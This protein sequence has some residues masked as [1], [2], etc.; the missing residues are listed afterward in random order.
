MLETSDRGQ[1]WGA[2]PYEALLK[3][4]EA[5]G[6]DVLGS[7][8]WLEG[9]KLYRLGFQYAAVEMLI[10]EYFLGEEEYQGKK[11]YETEWK[12][13]SKS[14]VY[15]KGD[16]KAD[17]VIVR[18][19]SP[20]ER[21]VPWRSLLDYLPQ[22]P[23]PLFVIDLSMKFLHTPEELS[24]L[25]LQLG[26][27]LSTIRE[28]LWDAH[29]SITGADEE[30]AKWINEVMGVNK[31]A[32]VN[33]RP[34]EV[35]WGYDA[36]KVIILRPD[37][38]TPL[39]PDDVMTADAFLIGGIVDKIPR[40]GLSRMLDSLV[41]WGVPRRIELRGSV[42]GVPE[43][44]NRIVEVLLKSRYVYNGDIE[45]AVITTMSKKDRVARAYRELVKYAS[46]KGGVT[47]VGKD[48]YD[49][50]RQWLPLSYDEFLEAAR[51]AHVSVEGQT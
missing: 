32:I 46:E 2:R 37:A 11:V 6:Y 1:G 18:K 30:T 4:M 17:A 22:P 7:R 15:G 39:K 40:P 35:L 33:A 48:F 26:V 3:L 16:V 38:S 14:I 45:K 49:K 5:Y 21:T 10:R 23:L 42:I 41:P 13:K 34:S 36:D 19:P 24:K 9:D 44:I 31:V 8:E 20:T 50:L 28:Y 47:T 29:L 27:T 12:G 51:R 43:R 25:R